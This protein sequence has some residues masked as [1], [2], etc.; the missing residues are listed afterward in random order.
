MVPTQRWELLGGYQYA[1]KEAGSH[2]IHKKSATRAELVVGGLH[3]MMERQRA[4]KP[5]CTWKLVLRCRLE[6][7]LRIGSLVTRDE[8]GKEELGLLGSYP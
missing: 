3:D 1:V 8:E 6:S 2:G 7:L 5:L 4:G